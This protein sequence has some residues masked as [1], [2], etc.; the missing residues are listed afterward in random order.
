M[1]N[2]KDQLV[3]SSGARSVFRNLV[4]GLVLLLLAACGL[5]TSAIPPWET[6]AL[7]ANVCPGDTV[8]LSWVTNSPRCIEGSSPIDIGGGC[9]DLE[10]RVTSDRTG[11][12]SSPFT[13]ILPEGTQISGPITGRTTF[14]FDGHD[15]RISMGP[16]THVVDVVLPDRIT[17]V[18]GT[19]TGSCSGDSAAWLPLSL[20]SGVFRSDGVRV[21]RIQNANDF[22][23]QI[24]VSFT[25]GDTLEFFLFP[26]NWT[27]EFDPALGIKALQVSSTPLAGDFRG[28]ECGVRASYPPNLELGIELACDLGSASEAIVMATPDTTSENQEEQPP[29][30]IISRDSLCYAGPGNPY[31]VVGSL[32][33]GNTAT[34]QGIGADENWLVIENP[35]LADVL[36]WVE[37]NDVEEPQGFDL[38]GLAVFPI[39]PVPTP[40]PGTEKEV[41]CLVFD[42]QNNIVCVPRACTPNDQPGGNCTP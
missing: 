38:S 29:E 3:T 30:I 37:R 19:L 16:Y 8:T 25:T 13:S 1:I 32:Q 20:A 22:S 23:I 17:N 14:T 5:D 36:C 39:P 15:D 10:V 4:L 18:P 11:T 12:L 33:R 34:V 40:T 6:S 28:V 27:P 21:V 41:G 42:A 35:R 24:S 9:P 26:W 31:P 7:P 2:T